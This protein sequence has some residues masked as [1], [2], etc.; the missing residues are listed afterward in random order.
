MAKLV[1]TAIGSGKEGHPPL[2]LGYI[3]SYLREFLKFDNIKIV[4]KESNPVKAILKEKP[5]LVGISGA[6]QFF[7]EA[8]QMA[9]D[10]KSASDIPTIIGGAHITAIPHTLGKEFDI[11]VLGEGEQV[12]MNLMQVCLDDHEFNSKNLGNIKG[13]AFHNKGK[14][15][16]NEREDLI[17]P[18]DRIP[19]PARDLFKMKEIYL[20]PRVTFSLSRLSRST[21]MLTSRG[22]TYNCVFCSS[23]CFWKIARFHSPE[24]VIGEIKELVK[25]YKI[26]EINIRLGIVSMSDN[27]IEII[28]K[29]AGLRLIEGQVERLVDILCEFCWIAGGIKGQYTAD[30][31][32]ITI[33]HCDIHK[34]A[35][36]AAMG[37]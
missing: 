8:S 15:V 26:N 10:I 33:C 5:D 35:V 20:I 7:N 2:A 27:G 36:A 22:C 25:N 21:H 14:V 9:K 19:Y 1:L 4:D 11:A 29:S 32:L 37:A 28:T 13:V 6:T 12:M 31:R 30:I 34:T 3:A 17:T 23:S 24:Y 16:I 18:L